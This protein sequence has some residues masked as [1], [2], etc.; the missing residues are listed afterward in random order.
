M[1]ENSKQN[2]LLDSHPTSVAAISRLSVDNGSFNMMVNSEASG[3]YTSKK[4][5]LVYA[6][7][8]YL[9]LVYQ[10]SL[11]IYGAGQLVTATFVQH[12][13]SSGIGCKINK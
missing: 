8:P 7:R 1:S 11:L 13:H 4:H 5:R 12:S 9:P 2:F 6:H 10:N 3:T